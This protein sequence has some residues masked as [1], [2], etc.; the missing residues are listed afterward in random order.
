M[1]NQFQVP[2][3]QQDLKLPI[4]IAIE[5]NKKIDIFVVIVDSVARISRDGKAP[6]K[7]FVEYK[8]KFNKGAK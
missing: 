1:S 4:K 2:R 7:E 6:I 3:T 8:A 5:A